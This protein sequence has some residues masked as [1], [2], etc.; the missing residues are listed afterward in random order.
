MK[1]LKKLA[2]VV[3]VIGVLGAAGAAFAATTITPAEIVS[4]L[5]GKTVT[6]LYQERSTG[7]T[8]GTIANEAGK[9]EEFKTQMLE[10]KKIVLDQRVK[11]GSLTQEQADDIYN[12]IKN[13]QAA[14]DG[15]GSA[16]IGRKYGAGF[17]QSCGMGLGQGAGAGMRNGAG[18]GGGMG[19]GRGLNR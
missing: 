1:R 15:T 2:A 10:Q 19:A 3:S 5:T 13:N 12:A 9:L 17:G 4:G 6:E 16:G 14:C 7:K 18:F 11:D 8:Y